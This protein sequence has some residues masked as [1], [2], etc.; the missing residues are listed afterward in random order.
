MMVK[1]I[2]LVII[3]QILYCKPSRV[4]ELA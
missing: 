4:V 3:R 2:H 1:G